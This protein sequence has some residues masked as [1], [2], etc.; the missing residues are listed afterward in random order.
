MRQD[1]YGWLHNR[2]LLA[3]LGYGVV[4]LHLRD[5]KWKNEPKGATG[6]LFHRHR[7][8]PR[9]RGDP[10]AACSLSLRTW[11]STPS[12]QQCSLPHAEPGLLLGAAW[13]ATLSN[14]KGRLSANGRHGQQPLGWDGPQASTLCYQ[15]HM[16]LN[17]GNSCLLFPLLVHFM[18]AWLIVSTIRFRLISSCFLFLCTYTGALYIGTFFPSFP[19]LIRAGLAAR[20]NDWSATIYRCLCNA[21]YVKACVVVG[22]VNWHTY[23][24]RVLL[25]TILYIPIWLKTHEWACQNIKKFSGPPVNTFKPKPA[26]ARFRPFCHMHVCIWCFFSLFPEH[27]QAIS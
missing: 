17:A 4:L 8:D 15:D 12:P 25:H 22:V 10:W 24:F 9:V 7:M 11:W 27:I 19:S 18:F 14:L 16:H 5:W 1:N 6:R 23:Y 20:L 2:E 3:D 26:K 13:P 21:S